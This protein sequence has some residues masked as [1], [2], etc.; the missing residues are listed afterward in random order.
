[1]QVTLELRTIIGSQLGEDGSVVPRKLDLR[2]V[3]VG[4]GMIKDRIRGV[5]VDGLGNCRG[6]ESGDGG[7]V[8]CREESVLRG[9][10]RLEGREEH[11]L[12]GGFLGSR[13]RRGCDIGEGWVGRTEGGGQVLGA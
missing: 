9:E 6:V 1:M 13:T 10:K 11:G 3:D 2:G 7:F 12:E 4:R 8:I 5:G